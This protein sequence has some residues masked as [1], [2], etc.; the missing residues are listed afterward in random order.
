MIATAKAPEKP[1]R[2]RVIPAETGMTLRNLLIRRVRDLDRDTAAELVKAGGVYINRLRIRLP[3]IRV[4]AGERVTVYR[5]ALRSSPLEPSALQIRYRAPDFVVI[6]KPAGVAVSPTRG[7]ARGTLS[8]AL[9]SRLESEGVARPYVGVVHRLDRGASGLVVLTTRSAANA[10]LHQQFVD[11]D[12]RR[13]YLIL[14]EGQPPD[15]LRCEAP[16]AHTSQGGVRIA[17]AD[18][19]SAKPAVTRFRRLGTR[20]F[21][22]QRRNLVQ[23]ELETGRTHQIRAHAAH[24]GFPVVGDRRYGAPPPLSR[25]GAAPVDL[26]FVEC[27]CLHAWRLRFNHPTTGEPLE[28]T[29]PP[30]AWAGVVEPS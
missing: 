3:M 19:P 1:V 10:S 25:L 6:D 24:A 8:E 18:E 17:K 23:A 4:A 2:F 16:L 14:V 5:E 29:S 28:F 22:G 7:T 13:T 20:E 21:D 30:P 27:L 26:E 9:A 15:E 11:H 12:I